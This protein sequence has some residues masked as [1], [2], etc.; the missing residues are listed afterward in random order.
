MQQMVCRAL[1][2][3]EAL[4]LQMISYLKK[5]LKKNWSVIFAKQKEKIAL[6]ATY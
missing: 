4:S 2:L 5:G 6:T 1:K 3:G